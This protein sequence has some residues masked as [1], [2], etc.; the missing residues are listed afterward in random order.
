MTQARRQ[1][2]NHYHAKY[3]IVF[4]LKNIRLNRFRMNLL[5]YCHNNIF[6]KSVTIVI[7]YKKF[8]GK[9]CMHICNHFILFQMCDSYIN[10]DSHAVNKTNE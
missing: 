10:A 7:P 8:Y 5:Q 9:F 6:F 4:M 3:K 1:Q 2:Q